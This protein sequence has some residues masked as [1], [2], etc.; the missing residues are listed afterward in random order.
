MSW[1]N[2]KQWHPKPYQN[3]LCLKCMEQKEGK[4]IYYQMDVGYEVSDNFQFSKDGEVLYWMP[5][6][7]IPE[8]L[9]MQLK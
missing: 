4:H 7:E 8:E 6:P 9:R 2:I 5:L 3:V 1:I